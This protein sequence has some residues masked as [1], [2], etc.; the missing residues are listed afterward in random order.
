VVTVNGFC[1]NQFGEVQDTL[2]ASL[3]RG[4]DMGAAVAVYVDGEPV[5]D[6]WGGH[7]DEQRSR[8]WEQDTIVNVWS[9]TKTMTALCALLLA[10]RGDLDL[11]APVARYWPEFAAAG[12]GAVEVR[13]LLSHTSGLY[14]WTEELTVA[15]LYDWEKLTDLLARQEPAWE[16]GTQSGY[17]SLTQGYL[18]GEVVRRITGRT[19]GAF[20]AQEVAG[21]LG[22]D[23]HIGFGAEH[24][25]RVAPVIDALGWGENGG[26]Y[27]G[28]LWN[29][30]KFRP[31][32]TW[33]PLWRRAEVPAANGH[34][35]AR[36][37]AAVQ[38]LL[39]CGGEVLGVRLLSDATCAKVFEEQSYGPDRRL[40]RVLRFGMGYGLPSAELP[41]GPN[42]RTCFWGGFGGALVVVD[43]DA[44]LTVSYVM[45][46]MT[47][48]TF[49]GGRGATVLKAVYNALAH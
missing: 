40:D 34:G 8:A 13:H 45:N 12:K 46:R 39:A 41:M 48:D 24:D 44:R 28:P 15:D 16:P 49:G 27:S 6:I 17:H 9:V 1:A 43:V 35:N 32:D 20:F 29:P 21:P 2:A 11:Y 7:L 5:V 33:S 3:E 19:L 23:F 30:A 14:T 38:S 36:S 26:P 18:V 47:P 10:D 4:E 42:P 37:V 31:A 25:H 22:A